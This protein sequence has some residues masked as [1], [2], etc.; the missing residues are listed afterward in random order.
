MI[1]TCGNI[2]LKKETTNV[3]IL[4]GLS[5]AV[6][7][8][9]GTKAVLYEDSDLIE[10]N[11]RFNNPENVNTKRLDEYFNENYKVIEMNEDII[12]KGDIQFLGAIQRFSESQLDLDSDFAKVLDSLTLK[13]SNNKPL[14]KR[15]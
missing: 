8:T 4:L 14:R 11:Y 5:I 6:P 2:I 9:A 15:F 1:D 3:A 10:C 12:I 7:S 13:M